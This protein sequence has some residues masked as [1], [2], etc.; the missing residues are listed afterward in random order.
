[1]TRRTRT[2]VGRTVRGLVGLVLAV[3]GS[4][5]AATG[6]ARD[7]L[8][9]LRVGGWWTPTV[10]ASAVALTVLCVYRTY[11]RFRPGRTRRPIILPSP[12]ARCAA[13]H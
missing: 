6:R 13:G 5:L 7:R 8:T 1:M 10:M 12:A 9:H 3:A 4:W 11:A 2:A